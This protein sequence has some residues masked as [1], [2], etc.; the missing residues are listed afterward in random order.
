VTVINDPVPRIDSNRFP[1]NWTELEPTAVF[2]K[3]KGIRS[4][5]SVPML[6]CPICPYMTFRRW[7]RWWIIVSTGNS[8]MWQRNVPQNFWVC[9]EFFFL[10][11]TFTEFRWF[12]IWDPWNRTRHSEDC[13]FHIQV[14]LCLVFMKSLL[15]QFIIIK[16]KLFLFLFF[17]FFFLLFQKFITSTKIFNVHHITNILNMKVEF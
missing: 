13:T 11:P 14:F 12:E 2:E 16:I 15:N 3:K 17:L 1:T 8:S 7:C 10:G 9:P 6:A 4:Y 5:Q